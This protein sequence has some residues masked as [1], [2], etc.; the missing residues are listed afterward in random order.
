MVMDV[1]STFQSLNRYSIHLCR[2][3]KPVHFGG[4]LDFLYCTWSDLSLVTGRFLGGVPTSICRF[5]SPVTGV[6]F[7]EAKLYSPNRCPSKSII[8]YVAH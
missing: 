8:G 2:R 4:S 1:L 5:F 7:T 3:N 6:R